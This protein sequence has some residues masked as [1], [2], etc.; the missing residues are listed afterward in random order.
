MEAPPGDIYIRDVGPTTWA[1]RVVISAGYAGELE[2]DW[3]TPEELAKDV[4]QHLERLGRPRYSG[5]GRE[6]EVDGPHPGTASGGGLGHGDFWIDVF[7]E[8]SSERDARER[9]GGALRGY[10]DLYAG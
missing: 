4:A 9:I 5:T 8:A 6:F 2:G 3:E 10:G 1:L 7:I